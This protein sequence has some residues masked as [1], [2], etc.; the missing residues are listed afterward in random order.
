MTSDH[1]PQMG[2]A[3][4]VSLSFAEW[5]VKTNRMFLLKVILIQCVQSLAGRAEARQTKT[6]GQL[7]EGI[8]ED[9]KNTDEPGAEE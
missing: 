8:E 3:C 5:L 7:R 4:R 1:L 2:R 6:D 9:P